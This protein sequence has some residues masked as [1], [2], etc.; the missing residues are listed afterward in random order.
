MDELIRKF[1]THSLSPGELRQLRHAFASMTNDEIEAAFSSVDEDDFSPADV[2]AEIE[3]RII[4]T[5]TDR[6]S[7]IRKRWL[8]S[9]WGIAAA[10]SVS[11][12][13][14]SVIV[15]MYVRLEHY[16]RYETVLSAATEI[17]TGPTER[18]SI[19]LPDG[20][21]VLMGPDS[22]LS[23]AIEDFNGSHRMVEAIGEL[24]FIVT[25]DES[26][27]FTVVSQDLE[28]RVLG[29]EFILQSDTVRT[30]IML[31]LL[32]GSVE[33]SSVRSGASVRL[34]PMELAIMDRATGTLKLCRPDNR[35]DAHAMLRGDL[36]FTDS[37]LDAVIQ[38]ISS[39]YGV[40]LSLA[41]SLDTSR[42]F[43]GY[44]PSKNLPEAL[45]ILEQAF[46]F[47][48]EMTPDSTEIVLCR[49]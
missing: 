47:S 2:S 27:P 33:M 44:I 18:V 48:T 39:T 6:I 36:S 34:Q 11:V 15:W 22:R 17:T 45:G 37:R 29:T 3:G 32:N 42:M 25:H 30:D 19:T 20:S 13:V 8:H 40:K 9:W 1:R 16:S 41:D 10:A 7:P 5:L 38:K 49:R 21:S 35:N 24:K 46:G 28:V 14:V 31:Y 23:Y 4:S 43:T 26:Q 12:V